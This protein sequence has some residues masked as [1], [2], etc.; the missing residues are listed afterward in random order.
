MAEALGL[1][2]V[3]ILDYATSTIPQT[4]A[5]RSQRLLIALILGLLLGS[6]GALVLETANTKIRGRY[7]TESLF[8]VPELGVIP[9]FGPQQL[10]GIR[11]LFK[12]RSVE[13]KPVD[14]LTNYESDFG[15]LAAEAY[16]RLRTNLVFLDTVNQVK[17]LVVTSSLPGEGKTT[18]AAN[19]A[20]AFAREGRRVLLIDGDLRRPRLHQ[21]FD[22]EGAAGFIDVLL[23]RVNGSGP[24]PARPI[25]GL[26]FLPRGEYDARAAE[27]LTGS[28][29]K[30]LIEGFRDTY[31]VIIFDTAPILLAS[32]ASVLAALADGVLLVVR[33]GT[34]KHQSVR[35]ALQ[36][37][38]AVR[39]NVVGF[40]LNDPE[41]VAVRENEYAY[42]KEYYTVET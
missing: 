26:D 22:A 17:T 42:T 9:A 13:I 29:M 12:G 34:S 7:D 14:A 25:E 33:A 2:Q 19:L 20:I 35:E 24:E 30:A 36:Q 28:R 23:G 27:V 4:Q 15:S 41:A 40:V 10:G 32:E 31:D 21:I 38:R 18:T 1:S 37:L 5:N 39:A 3:Q 16:R 8:A 6:G 11:K